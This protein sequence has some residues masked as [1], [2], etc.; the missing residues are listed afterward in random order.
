MS[1]YDAIGGEAA[2]G[3][4]VVELYRRLLDDSALK[5][6]FDGVDMDQLARHQRAFITAALGGPGPDTGRAMGGAH[7]GLGL[8]DDARFGIVHGGTFASLAETICS[9]ATYEAV[10]D[11][12]MLA[13]GMSNQAT[14]SKA[15]A[16][17]RRCGS[18]G[19]RASR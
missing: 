6:Y 4:V 5:G 12:G 10:K 14:F 8:T 7:T 15:A 17:R 9:L 16:P 18:P 19:S 13:L 2:V 11:D 3:A 1:I